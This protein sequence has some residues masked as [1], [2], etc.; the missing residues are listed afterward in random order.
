MFD[1][2]YPSN[3]S[4]NVFK[5]QEDLA[6]FVQWLGS[7]IHDRVCLEGNPVLLNEPFRCKVNVP[8]PY[9]KPDESSWYIHYFGHMFL[10]EY[11]PSLIESHMHQVFEIERDNYEDVIE[12][13]DEIDIEE[14]P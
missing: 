4:H 13:I 11:I 8:N 10:K 1:V 6:K 14:G 7:V 12:I 5:T 9:P 3:K 2:L